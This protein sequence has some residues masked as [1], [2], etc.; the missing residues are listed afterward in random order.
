RELGVI[1]ATRPAAVG[2]QQLPLVAAVAAQIYLMAGNL[3]VYGYAGLTAGAAHLVE[4]FGDAAL[5]ARY[6]PALYEGR[7]TGT[8]ALTEPHAGSSLADLTTVAAPAGDHHRISGA[9]IFISGGDHDL[10]ENIVHMV[11]ARIE[12]APAGV[13][14]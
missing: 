6:L 14:G 5:R 8:M 7:W 11:L 3:S 2:G 12:G 13:K 9:K 1:A 10:A 4:A